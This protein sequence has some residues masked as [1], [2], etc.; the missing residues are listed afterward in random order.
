[1]DLTK[2][3]KKIKNEEIAVDASELK[4]IGIKED[5]EKIE[6]AKR[7][8]TF[9]VSYIDDN[10]KEL[11][12][13]ITSKIMDYETRLRYDRALVELSGGLNFD[14][15]PIETKNKYICMARAVCQIVDPPE[16]LLKKIGEDLEFA[17]SIGGKLVDHEGRF[18]RFNGGEGSNTTS[19]PRF[20]IS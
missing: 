2:L 20:Q 19:K 16:W 13:N 14:L 9:S 3:Q 12:S 8:E 15:L 1:M 5:K 17:Y 11:K 7:I 4:T 10:G 18:F 6:F